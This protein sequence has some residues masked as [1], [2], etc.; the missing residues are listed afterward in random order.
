MAQP[1][2]APMPPDETLG[3]GCRITVNAIDPTTGNQVTGVTVSNFLLR[4]DAVAGGDNLAYGS[5]M[6]VGNPVLVRKV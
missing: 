5:F 2:I 4:V 3:V 6:L 1:L